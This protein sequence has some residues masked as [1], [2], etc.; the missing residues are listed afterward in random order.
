MSEFDFIHSPIEP[1]LSVIEASAGTGKTFAIS[2]LVPRLLL[3]GKV[4]HLEKILLVTFTN[5]AAGELAGRVRQVLE[6]LHAIP[7]PDEAQKDPGVYRLRCEFGEREGF[8]NTLAQAIL[9]IDRL[10]VSTIHSFCQ[11]VLHEEGVLCGMPVAPELIASHEEILE[12]VLHDLWEEKI[13]NDPAAAAVAAA[14]GWNPESDLAFLKMALP[15]NLPVLIPAASGFEEILR[16]ISDLPKK[17]TPE[18]LES[19]REFLAG[20]SCWKNNAPGKAERDKLLADLEPGKELS[21]S[22]ISAALECVKVP[23]L[24]NKKTKEGKAAANKA[25]QQDVFQVAAEVAELLKPIHWAFQAG[26]LE[27]VREKLAAELKASR[28]VTYDGLIEAVHQA[29]CGEHGPELARR[30]RERYQVG[31]IDE[32]QDTDPR[33]FEI[34]R[35]I[36]IGADGNAHGQHSLMLI[37]DPKQAIYGFRGADVNTYLGAKRQAGSVFLLTRTFRAPEPLVQAVN[38]VFDRGLS[39]LK[40]GLDFTP[41]VS[42]QTQVTKLECPCGSPSDPME[43]WLV[44]DSQKDDYSSSGKR[45]ELIASSVASEIVRLLNA[46]ATLVTACED[47]PAESSPVRPGSFAVLVNSRKEASEVAAALKARGVPAISAGGDDIMASEEAGEVLAILR[48]MENPRQSRLQFAALVTRMLGHDI[49]HL[50]AGGHDEDGA[51][52]D[53]IRW[54]QTLER[55]GA[56]AA[57]VLIDREKGVT[58][59]LARLEPGERRITNLRHLVDLLQHAGVEYGNHCGRLVRWLEME[60]QRAQN[61]SEVEERQLRLESDAEAVRIVTMHASKGLEYPL[62]FC[63]F[64]WSS[65]E[66]NGTQKLSV[67]G[68]SAHLINIGLADES[69][70]QKLVRESLEDRLRLAYVALTRAKVKVWVYAGEVNG[71]NA[72][73]GTATDWLFRPDADEAY[74]QWCQRQFAGSRGS[75]QKDGL[76]AILQDAGEGL[77]YLREPPASTDDRW[78]EGSSC[79]QPMISPAVVPAI[80]S[81]WTLTSFS[82]LTRESHHYDDKTTAVEKVEPDSCPEQVPYGGNVFQ[83]APGGTLMG[84]AIHD[85]IEGWDFSQVGPK[86]LRE[87]LAKYPLP[88]SKRSDAL[89]LDES[90]AGML[91]HLRAAILPGLECTMAEACPFPESSEWHFHLPIRAELDARSLAAAFERHGQADYA[92][93]LRAL[94]AEGL[95]GYLHGFLDRIAFWEGKWGVVD[96]KTNHLGNTDADYQQAQLLQCASQ[97]HYLLQ[98]HIYLVALRRYLGPDTPIAGAWLVFLRGVRA[99]S[100]FSILHINPSAE[101]LNDLGALFFQPALL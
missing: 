96:W 63:P 2:H 31:L 77:I 42:G 13:A 15:L 60:I 52:Q 55:R 92:R 58:G 68:E 11:R 36:F 79:V 34:F 35:R 32:S 43:V 54:R 61:R 89:P 10:A 100:D 99:N 6:K 14:K 45:T 17:C 78:D 18:R 62:V 95:Q 86:K 82:Q 69:W 44:P 5:D 39:L 50:D 93:F 4:D 27:A 21:T 49:H 67:P 90:V 29:L 101:L 53:F 75:S 64:L 70:K 19:L 41:G 88:E 57:F 66:P 38:A 12:S 30:L 98:A 40:A 83:S 8:A 97:S 25:K 28:K 74:D 37:G 46:R 33:Q 24:I 56:A 22:W 9:N 71:N 20:V 91:E 94:T 65:R 26:L 1:G 7:L 81:A 76:T 72:T 48:A 47:G 73:T 51:Q 85:W 16:K 87:H 3:E 59:R 80:P 23:E 84:T